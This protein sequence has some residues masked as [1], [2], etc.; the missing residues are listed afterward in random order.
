VSSTVAP[1]TTTTRP[2]TL[3]GDYPPCGRVTLLEVVDFINLWVHG[4][5]AL[6]DVVKLIKA[7]AEGI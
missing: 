4:E 2:C 3:A 6:N 1:T 7:W 5:A